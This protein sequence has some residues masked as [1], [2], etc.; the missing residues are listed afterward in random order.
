M[1]REAHIP[2]L[3]WISAAIVAHLAGG[4]SAVQV[5][6]VVEDRAALRALER[7]VRYGLRPPDTTI[8]VL[9][10]DTQ[11]TEGQKVAP[12]DD[13][14]AKDSDAKDDDSKDDPDPLKPKPLPPP[15]KPKATPPPP[16]K[17]APPPLPPPPKPPPP[18]PPPL[19]PL[20]EKPAPV[21]VAPPP[22]PPPP[23]PEDHR[24][25]IRQHADKEEPDN[26]TAQRIA[27]EAHT[28]KEETVARIRSH[29]QDAEKPS[30]GS[31]HGPKGEIGDS[32]H[33]KEADSENHKGD[34]KHA[35]GE[36]NQ[37]ST[38]ATHSNPALPIP[39]DLSKGRAPTTPGG[40]GLPAGRTAQAPM[41][42][43]G[44]PPTSGGQGPASP[45]VQSGDRGGYTLDPANPGGDGKS[46]LAGKRHARPSYQNPTRVGDL[47]LGG[48]GLPGV[49]NLTMPGME[50][51]V[52]EDKLKQERAAD[53][54][55][56]RSAHRGSWETNKFEKWRAAIENYEPL[57]TLGN[58]TS[59][60]AA[61]VPF[62]T[63]LNTIHNRLHPIFAEE[64]LASLDNLPKA[65][66]LNQ[67]L[68]TH[69]EIVLDKEQGRIVHMGVT[70]ASGVTAFD[71]VAL[72]SMSRAQP[73]G[74]APDAIVSP[75]G[76]VY[77][78]WE[79]HRDPF[80]A[81]STRNARPYL[82]KEAPKTRTPTPGGRPTPPPAPKST[83]EQPAAPGPLLPLREP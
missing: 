45:E 63:Y 62:A 21:V 29:D 17:V 23:P 64:F 58:Q 36:S 15:P 26:P 72:N 38:T 32:D 30:P 71:I 48:N 7:D 51:A 13:K 18:P 6:Q 49:P 76:N 5:A 44:P 79:F 3:L 27:D 73:F 14:L 46:R 83:D 24:I 22:P 2:L 50:A 47:G 31:H 67:N 56:R 9:T 35:P 68:V 4:G 80:D 8:E 59:L 65:N 12:P 66:A 54:A 75:D 55:A 37:A 52:G 69:L 82:L 16:V 40:K 74:K 77:L 19:K 11:P 81:C 41:P 28:T 42:A 10:D 33:D 43:G 57:V 39:S 78:H 61:R 1:S 60:N 70:K 20:V 25:A 34:D 53:G